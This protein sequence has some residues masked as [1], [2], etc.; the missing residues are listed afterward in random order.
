M[1]ENVVMNKK[2]IKKIIK[3]NALTKPFYKAY[4]AVKDIQR[5]RRREKGKEIFI[6]SGESVMRDVQKI[7]SSYE[8]IEFFFA[9][10]TLL[11]IIR[12]GKLLGRDMDLDMV[13]LLD[14]DKEIVRFRDYIVKKG[15]QRLHSF[16]VDGVGINQDAFM[17]KNIMIDLNYAKT[18]GNK[19]YNYN[20]YDLPEEK[21]KI[22]IF[23]FTF[24]GCVKY[25]FNGFDINVPENPELY[26][27][28]TYG[29]DWRIPNP[30]Y[31]YWENPQTIKTELKGKV[32]VIN[33]FKFH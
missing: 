6:D 20:F 28:E 32:E 10:G 12:D 16:S 26:L 13:V 1:E 17:Y 18:N 33:Q 5:N 31:I 3:D 8:G 4:M 14:D 29:K 2:E 23:P 15:F 22:L 24:T 27:E 21:N 30:E 7:L 25:N 9:Y 19:K 11:G